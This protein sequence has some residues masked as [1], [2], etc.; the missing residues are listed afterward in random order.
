MHSNT[1]NGNEIIKIKV[2][3]VSITYF[4]LRLSSLCFAQLQTTKDS[5]R[6]LWL[7]KE[8]E[9]FQNTKSGQQ[10]TAVCTC[11]THFF[12][13]KYELRLYS[14][15]ISNRYQFYNGF[16]FCTNSFSP[17]ISSTTSAFSK[18]VPYGFLFTLPYI[19]FNCCVQS[20][21]PV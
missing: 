13:G 2:W 18:I 7:L 4:V 11:F 10:A 16:V 14:S 5:F 20:G 17:M 15:S 1:Q 8:L 19:T 9:C 21:W 12:N 3:L 6:I